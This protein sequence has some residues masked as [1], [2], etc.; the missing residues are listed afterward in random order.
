MHAAV[1]QLRAAQGAQADSTAK[2]TETLP[3]Q[4]EKV[5]HTWVETM[6]RTDQPGGSTRWRLV[7]VLRSL[8]QVEDDERGAAWAKTATGKSKGA[9]ASSKPSEAA[10]PASHAGGGLGSSAQRAQ[11]WDIIRAR[12]VGLELM[13]S[14]KRLE[15]SGTT[16]F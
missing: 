8:P 1:A 5:D 6:R 13:C 14:K 2:V 12:I 16:A 4:Q 3:K 11:M 15:D 9:M 10:A 7:V